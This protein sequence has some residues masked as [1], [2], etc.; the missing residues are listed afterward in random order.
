MVLPMLLA[1]AVYRGDVRRAI[2]TCSII[3]YVQLL[4]VRGSFLQTETAGCVR[5]Y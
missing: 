5:A 1:V 4:S 3:R 2:L